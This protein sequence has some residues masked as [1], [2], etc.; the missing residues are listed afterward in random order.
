MAEKS[1]KTMK[2]LVKQAESAS[3]EYMDYPVSEPGEGELLVKV[4]K[5]SI[6]GSDLNLYSWNEGNLCITRYQ[7]PSL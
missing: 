4:A 7:P 2:A 5:V 6:C 3:Y 1:H